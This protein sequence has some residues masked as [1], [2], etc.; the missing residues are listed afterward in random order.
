MTRS[1]P[2]PETEWCD[3]EPGDFPSSEF[4]DSE[5]GRLHLRK[6]LHNTAAETGPGT[7]PVTDELRVELVERMGEEKV[8]ELLGDE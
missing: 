2:R 1:R 4:V 7:L 6:P 8:E 3:Y 5:W